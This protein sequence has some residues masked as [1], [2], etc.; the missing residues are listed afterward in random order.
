MSTVDKEFSRNLKLVA[1]FVLSFTLIGSWTTPQVAQASSSPDAFEECLLDRA[2]D[3][4][5]SM[6]VTRLKMAYDLTPPVREWSEWMRF[7]EFEHMSDSLHREILP[8]SATRWGE[9]VAMSG[10][11]DMSQCDRIHDMWMN[12]TGHQANILN[13][14]VGYVVIGAYVDDS[15]WWVTQLFFDA[16]GYQ[17]SCQGAF[18]DDDASVFEDD[19][20]TIARA[21]I[22]QGCNPP[23]NDR[24]CP[25]EPITRGAIAAF[26]TRALSL[27]DGYEVDFDDV[28]GSI[29][30]D[31]I[32]RLAGA[33]IARGCNPPANSL[34]CPDSFVTRGQMAAFLTRALDLPAARGTEFTDDNTSSFEADIESL[35]AAGITTGCNPPENTRF[36]PNDYVTRGQMATFLARALDL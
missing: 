22:T 21:G 28:G 16:E 9:N 19:I 27:P 4:R 7:N 31:Q 3:A 24:F 34:F 13:P 10:A 23:A 12:S 26:L 30:A 25:D 6:G 15:G 33:D 35:A 17:T 8:E 14:K 36:C 32:V 2:N 1:V 29:F 18:C 11:T 20:E 5:S